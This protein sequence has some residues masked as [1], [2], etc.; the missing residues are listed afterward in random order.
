MGGSDGWASEPNP[1]RCCESA[2]SGIG[3]AIAASACG[4]MAGSAGA[5]PRVPL[6][7]DGCPT[8]TRVLS[9]KKGLPMTRQSGTELSRQIPRATAQVEPYVNALGA[10]LAVTFLLHYGGAELYVRSNPTVATE[11]ATLIGVDG[12]QALASHADKMPK[13]VPLVKAWLTAMLDW[14]GYTVAEIAR[15]LRTSDVS[16]RRMIKVQ[17]KKEGRT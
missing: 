10:E 3:K 6:A 12:A 14:Q 7:G 17:R 16:V 2:A 5:N 4:A 13:R 8:V 15:K 1:A 11:Y 9:I